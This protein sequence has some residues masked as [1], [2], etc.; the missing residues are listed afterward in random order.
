MQFK[1]RV[2]KVVSKIPKGSVLTYKEVAKRA[3]SPKAVRAVGNIIKKNYDPSIPCHRV[4]RSDGKTG[5][6]NRGTKEKIRRLK[7]EGVEL[8]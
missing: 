4:I 1:E 6:Y 5:G 3:G 2:L 8:S 7:S